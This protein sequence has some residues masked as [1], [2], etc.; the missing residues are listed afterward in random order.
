MLRKITST[1]DEAVSALAFVPA[2]A[3]LM[4][5]AMPIQPGHSQKT[6][7]HNIEELHEG[8]QYART[9]KKFGAKKANAQAVA[10]ALSE[11]RKTKKK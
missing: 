11:S 1:S 10:I 2:M 5:N 6:I 4:I 9:K 8:P 7:S 3:R